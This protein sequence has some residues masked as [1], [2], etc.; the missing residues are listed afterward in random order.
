LGSDI[1]S[2]VEE[3]TENLL[4]NLLPLD[5]NIKFK[6]FYSSFRNNLKIILKTKTGN[7]IILLLP[8]LF[9]HLSLKDL[10]S[11]PLEAMT[12]G[13]PVVASFSSS[14]PEVVGEGG[15]LI[16]PYNAVDISLA[17][18]N[19]LTDSALRELLINEGLKKI[20]IFSWSK[21]AEETLNYLKII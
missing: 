2:G 11:P 18:K 10:V 8:F 3:Y 17:I 15:I 13:T 1:K 7:F 21:C 19:I 20:Q 5:K 16:D 12:C 6:L 4:A 9:T 14:L